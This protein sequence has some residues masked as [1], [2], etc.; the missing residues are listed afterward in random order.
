MIEPELANQIG[1]AVTFV[2]AAL[3]ITVFIRS[4]L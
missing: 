4:K 3:T 2:I 1:I